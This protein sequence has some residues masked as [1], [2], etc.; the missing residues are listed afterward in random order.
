MHTYSRLQSSLLTNKF[1]N[2]INKLPNEIYK[3]EIC[4]FKYV[5][6]T[7][8]TMFKLLGFNGINIVK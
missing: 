3:L 6:H 5:I 1:K 7:V 4:I 8:Y 2:R